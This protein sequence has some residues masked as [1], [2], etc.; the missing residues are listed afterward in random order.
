[1]SSEGTEPR[2]G[3]SVPDVS[4]IV[5]TWNSATDLSV[6]LASAA[7]QLGVT[8][9]LVVVD[10]GSSDGSID[11]ARSTVPTIRVIEMGRNTGFAAAMNAAIDATSGRY[12]LALNPDCRLDPH[13]L[14][15]VVDRLDADPTVGSASGRL[16]RAAGRRLEST[17]FLDSTGIRFTASGRHLDRGAGERA[18][19][20]YLEE[21]PIVGPSGA[22]AIYRRSALD[23]VRISTGYF[24]VDFFAY[25]EDADLALRLRVA[26]WD[27][28]YLPAAVAYHRR[29]NTPERR[30]QMTPAVN[31]HSVKNRYLLRINNYSR[32]ELVRT[33][34][35]TTIRDFVVLAACLTV[36]R[37]SLP[38]Y[39]WLWR[40]RRRLLAKRREISTL[41]AGR[42]Q[43]VAVVTAE[44]RQSRPS[45]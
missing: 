40:H 17:G 30:R 14:A 20:R 22:A 13:F 7:S 33:I 45:A 44:A 19:G 23:A 4:I 16:F 37:T 29:A 8:A 1:M 11:V 15:R 28:L 10:N 42:A 38:A 9:E 25:R 21:G 43:P 2:E 32:S 3:Q 36:E 6:C 31:F 24:D 5:V 35:P 18:V 27:S 41:R 39:Q 26:G 34:V 12:V